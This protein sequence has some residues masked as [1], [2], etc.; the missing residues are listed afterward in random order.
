MCDERER[1]IGYLYDEVDRDE[2]QAIDS[3]LHECP[4]C[5]REIAAL[6][7]VRQ[8][9]LAWDVPDHEPIW[10]P[11][12]QMRPATTSWR[13]VP[14]WALGLAASLTILAGLTGAVAAR[15]FN[16]L[17]PST[18]AT[19]QAPA[20]VGAAPT[21]VPTPSVNASSAGVSPRDLDALE[22]RILQRMQEQLNERMELVATHTPDA[23]VSRP[24]LTPVA[25]DSLLQRLERMEQWQGDQINFNAATTKNVERLSS[26][27]RSYTNRLD[28]M[29][30][31]GYIGNDFSR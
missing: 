10:R 5:R 21:L 31:V 3:H 28:G 19:A 20:N 22:A 15:W 18:A 13:Q 7:G 24:G 29:T 17:V 4:V 14:G 12:V 26:R 6:R 30:P 8:D 11:V 16:P 1:L 25:L 23:R 2:R 27:Q 9:L